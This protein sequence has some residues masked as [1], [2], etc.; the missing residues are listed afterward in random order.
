MIPETES[1]Q[2][3]RTRFPDFFPDGCPP[4]KAQPADGMVYRLVENDPPANQDF[5]CHVELYPK[6]DYRRS[7]N[8]CQACAISVF[9]DRRDLEEMRKRNPAFQDRK[10]AAGSLASDHGVMDKDSRKQFG[11]HITLWPFAGVL[12]EEVFEVA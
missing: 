9:E 3:Q 12:L 1:E 4:D 6:K 5:V 7:G 8:L 11:Y 10:I 2:V